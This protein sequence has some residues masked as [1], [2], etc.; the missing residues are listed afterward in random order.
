MCTTLSSLGIEPPEIDVWAFA[1]PTIA[2]LGV[3]YYDYSTT[4]R[5]YT[6]LAARVDRWRADLTA[7]IPEA[8]VSTLSGMPSPSLSLSR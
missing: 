4:E 7:S 6:D 5:D 3:H 1:L 2:E 8:P